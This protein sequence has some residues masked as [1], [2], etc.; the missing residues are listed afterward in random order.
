M[1]AEL[2]SY[3]EECDCPEIQKGWKPKVGDKACYENT[4][5]LISG[6]VF[7]TDKTIYALKITFN[8][9]QHQYN[10][11]DLKEFIFLPSLDQL[12]EVM[13]KRFKGLK[14]ANQGKR[15]LC[16]Y[17]KTLTAGK[18]GETLKLACLRAVKEIKTEKK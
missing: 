10:Y 12:L 3:I 6:L 1:K 16:V 8:Y 11:T 15:F 17:E 2:K 4:A 7:N 18:Y 5:C 13:G 14:P 9:V